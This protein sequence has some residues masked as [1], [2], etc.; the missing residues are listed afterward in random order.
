MGY[1]MNTSV[2]TIYEYKKGQTNSSAYLHVTAGADPGFPIGGGANRPG[3]GA[4]IQN[5]QSFQKTA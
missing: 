4:N 5:C 3:G 2:P 1:G